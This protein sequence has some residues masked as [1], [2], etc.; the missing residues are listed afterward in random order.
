MR[1]V[2]TSQ[3]KLAFACDI[4]C[5]RKIKPVLVHRIRDRIRTHNIKGPALR[6]GS[7]IYSALAFEKI[8]VPTFVIPIDLR[9][10]AYDIPYSGRVDFILRP[11]AAGGGNGFTGGSGEFVIQRKRRELRKNG[12]GTR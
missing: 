11:V 6:V 9:H 4:Y 3:C 5:P 10:F 1:I 2:R 8:V 12:R 7:Q